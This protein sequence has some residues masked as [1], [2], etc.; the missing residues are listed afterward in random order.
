MDPRYKMQ[1]LAA[2]R[3]GMLLSEVEDS[4]LEGFMELKLVKA[5]YPPAPDTV[6]WAWFGIPQDSLDDEEGIDG[7]MKECSL[8]LDAQIARKKKAALN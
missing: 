4:L 3:E 8:V 5:E 1:T 7:F 6:G 2:I